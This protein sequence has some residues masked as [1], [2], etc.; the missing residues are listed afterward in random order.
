MRTV[1][2]L[3]W[4]LVPVLAGAYHYGPGQQKMQMDQVAEALASAD[5][6]AAEG[7]WAQAAKGYD[8]ALSLLPAD[9][10]V[11]SRKIRLQKAKAQIES[12]GLPDAHADLKTLVEELAGDPKADPQLLAQAREAQAL[13]QYY[14]VWLMR[15][16]G[17]GKEDWGPEI[18]D[19]RQSY[20]LLAEQAE[21]QGDV[22]AAR[23][24]SENVESAIR[25]A[26]IDLNDLQGLPL[27][28]PC[29]NCKN[30]SCKGGKCKNPGKS[31]QK[32]DGPKDG[33]G[34]SSGPPPDGSGQ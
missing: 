11:E 27:P 5:Q 32:K 28:K 29:S 30:G 14:L 4:L 20:K 33:R 17:F 16:E 13:S 23:K 8:D 31:P 24:Q 19:A 2:L 12:G 15:L 25:L 21:A 22:D 10:A 34:A 9:R 26:R 18:E 3:G 1:L 7:Q 6:L